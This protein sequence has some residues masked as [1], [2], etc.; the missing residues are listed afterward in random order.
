M[1]R[2]CK[3]EK[4]TGCFACYNSCKKNA[5]TM[6]EDKNG[7]I[8]PKIDQ[9]K[10]INCGLCKKICPVL[11]EV[12]K[13]EPEECYAAFSKDKDIRTN[14]T[15]GGIGYTLYSKFIE[16]K[17][18][19]YGAKFK[20]GKLVISRT[21]NI[22][23]IKKFQGSKYVHAYVEDAYLQVK[24]DLS[25]DKKVLFIA[26]ACQIAGLKRFL[27]KEYN[28]LYLVDIV[29]HGVPS[30]K[31]LKDEIKKYHGMNIDEK[32]KFR[33]NNDYCLKYENNK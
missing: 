13:I 32:L 3:K 18:V 20:D 2:I 11:N 30:Q 8:H 4:C 6:I 28:N 25:E 23:E 1:E 31:Y 15:S 5:I 26:T 12:K 22:D 33:N 10:C 16:E 21:E 9:N 29:C 7:F 17:G 24:K 19:V 14:S 27:I